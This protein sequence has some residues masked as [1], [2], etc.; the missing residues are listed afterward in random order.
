[1]KQIFNFYI[2]KE[3]KDNVIEK[4]E[5]Y[6]GVHN[7][8]QLSALIRVLLKDFLN[9]NDEELIKAILHKLEFE[10]CESTSKN[11]RSRL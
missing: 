4:I 10:Y 2:D 9:C 7:K 8:G 6:N 1:M 3:V 11:K 5:K